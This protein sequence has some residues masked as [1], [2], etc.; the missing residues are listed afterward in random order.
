MYESLDILRLSSALARNAGQRQA[1]AAVNVANAD[2]PGYRAQALP[3]F[4]A[5]FDAQA[6]RATRLGHQGGR[7]LEEAQPVE[8]DG[9][10]S[11]NGNTVSIESE[12][13]AS[14]EASRD[15]G[16]ALAIWRHT[17]TVLRTSLGR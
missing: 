11:P 6:M 17:I 13:F 16:R 2:T 4:A 5:T 14:A 12:M 1:L 7:G 9:E 15:H 10:A 8:A 3:S